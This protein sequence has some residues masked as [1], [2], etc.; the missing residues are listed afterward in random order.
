MPQ[1]S[2]PDL[3]IGESTGAAQHG[4][5]DIARSSDSAIPLLLMFPVHN[6][7]C[8][9][10]SGRAGGHAT[11]GTAVPSIRIETEGTAEGIEGT[12]PDAPAFAF[13]QEV[14]SALRGLLTALTGLVAVSWVSIAVY[15]AHD[16]FAVGWTQGA[17]MGLAQSARRGALYPPL[18]DGSHY[19]GTRFMP[20]AILLHA[21]LARLTDDYLFSGKV[22]SYLSFG[23]LL[24]CT[25]AVLRSLRCPTY[26]GMALSAAVLASGTGLFVASGIGADALPV[27]LQLCAVTVVVRSNRWPET[28]LAAA[29]CVLAFFTKGSALWAPLAISIWFLMKDR[30]RLLI[31]LPA[32]VGLSAATTG[33]FGLATHGRLFSNVVGLSFSGVSNAAFVLR[34]LALFPLLLAHAT[35]ATALLPLAILGTILAAKTRELTIYHL[36]LGCAL[37]IIAVVLMDVGVDFNHLLDLIVLVSIVVGVMA[38]RA[39]PPDRPP[40][41]MGAVVLAV[42]SWALLSSLVTT[43]FLA[44]GGVFQMLNGTRSAALSSRPLAAYLHQTDVILSE[45]PTIPI[46]LGQRPVVLDAFALFRIGEKHPS[47]IRDLTERI[48]AKEF[49]KVVLTRPLDADDRSWYETIHFGPSI[50]DAL[51]RNY[52]QVV[53]AQEY[54]VFEPRPG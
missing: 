31:F 36:S 43:M 49:S 51:R 44:S 12:S 5:Y 25:V 54:Y 40:N 23:F 7:W 29:L 53:V 52:V 18:Y 30:R 47:W 1:T 2:W 34:P 17:W 41:A 6:W 4:T 42:L 37:V 22:L 46:Q 16:R 32:F 48:E 26:L 35:P 8:G 28:V 24:V 15:H 50:F 27:A 20:I 13:P 14:A 38:S 39:A 3:R 21:Q 33:L 19:G 10:Y 11:K 45:D 9:G